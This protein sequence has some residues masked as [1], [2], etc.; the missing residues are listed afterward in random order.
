MEA[1]DLLNLIFKNADKQIEQTKQVLTNHMDAADRIHL[2]QA[3]ES[4]VKV[5]ETIAAN[6]TS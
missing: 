2:R 3:S 4:L 6:P 5:A 1:D